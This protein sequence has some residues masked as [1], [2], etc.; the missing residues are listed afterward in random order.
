ML[1]T[2]RRKTLAGMGIARTVAFSLRQASARLRNRRKAAPIAKTVEA[3]VCRGLGI[4]KDGEEVTEQAMAE[5]AH[6]F[7]GQVPDHVLDAMR[8]LF[9]LGTRGEEDVV[10]QALLLHGGA[11]GLDHDFAGLDDDATAVA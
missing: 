6:R 1:P 10:D 2:S 7:Q 9:K 3:V 8:A 5:F 4:I 11:S